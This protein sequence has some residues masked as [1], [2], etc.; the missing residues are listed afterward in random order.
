MGNI[1]GTGLGATV[2]AVGRVVGGGVG[3]PAIIVGFAVGIADGFAL[4]LAVVGSRVGTELGMDVLAAV[5]AIVGVDWLTL[6]C[7]PR[8]ASSRSSLSTFV[9]LILKSSTE[10]LGHRSCLP[11]T[12]PWSALF[13][14]PNKPPHTY[15]GKFV[16][17]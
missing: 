14:A 7:V 1:V 17:V 4:G 15:D 9:E 10:A 12:G 2:G 6:T 3:G 13:N 8:R 5:G 16:V 11:Q